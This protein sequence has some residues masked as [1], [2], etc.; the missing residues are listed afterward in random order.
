MIAPT[1]VPRKNCLEGCFLRARPVGTR[2]ETM[3][4]TVEGYARIF[5]RAR[6]PILYACLVL[7]LAGPALGDPWYE[8]YEKGEEAL[9]GQNWKEAVLQFSQA[10]EKRGDPGVQLRTSG[11]NFINYHPYLKLGIAYYNLGQYDAALQALSTEESFAA[12]AKSPSDLENL[13]AFRELAGKAKGTAEQQKIDSI[14]SRALED[15]RAF[16][17]KGQLDEAMRVLGN[18]LAVNPDGAEGQALMQHLREEVKTQEDQKES[19]GR[20]TI[21]VNEGKIFMGAGKYKEAS[22]S[23]TQALSLRQAQDGPS[24]PGAVAPTSA[25]VVGKLVSLQNRVEIRAGSDGTWRLASPNQPL[26]SGDMVRTGPD[27]RVS[28][29]YKNGTLHR[30]AENTEIVIRP[31]EGA[32][33]GRSSRGDVFSSQSGNTEIQALLD[34][35]Q[36][37]LRDELQSSLTAAQREARTRGGLADVSHVL[38]T[39]LSPGRKPGRDVSKEII[40]AALSKLQEILA[41]DQTNREA[42]DLQARLLILQTSAA[43]MSE[44]TRS[45]DEGRSFLKE[46]RFDKSIASFNKAIALDPTNAEAN[47]YVRQAY[48]AIAAA[49]G[50]ASRTKAETLLPPIVEITNKVD[51]EDAG[52]PFQRVDTSTFDLQ[53]IVEYDRP[54]VTIKITQSVSDGGADERVLYEEALPAGAKDGDLYRNRFAR[55]VTLRPGLT[56]VKVRAAYPTPDG[57]STER[58]HRFKYV[59]PW[60]RSPWFYS[61]MALLGICALGAF[62]SYRIHHR[63]KLLKRRFNPY[64]AGAPVLDEDMFVGREALLSRILQTIHNNSI[65]LY[66][67]RRIGKTTLQHHLKKRLQHVK[68]PEYDF[69]P[70]FIDLQGTPQERF[71]ATLAEDIFNELDPLVDGASLGRHLAEGESS[72]T[73]QA[74]IRDIRDVLKALK[75]RSRKKVKLVLL[76]DEVD[77]L[78]AY[79]PQINQRL[80]S[81]FMR[82]FA[83]DLVAVV[84]G[85]A[86]KKHWD[87]EG[88]PWYNF[89][90]EIEVKPFTRKDAEELIEK[91]IKGIF[92][93]ETGAVDRIID[94]TECK[95]YLIQKVC[96]ALIN[97]LHEE[98]R[99]RITVADVEALARPVVMEG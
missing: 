38:E 4:A 30:L 31:G 87:S 77:E 95:P 70:V 42:L 86:I 6:G 47:S 57:L 7:A 98:K 9:R 56:T 46:G 2:L 68:D 1:L 88:S 53:G 43:R 66:G 10:V 14:V 44:I 75:D 73:Y 64:V 74:F 45:L 78:N 12:I 33:V 11:V 40:T 59:R 61:A 29:L 50:H 65:L 25:D 22:S 34:E 96:I 97:R 91:P 16:E 84:S 54:G 89:F 79:E 17:Q 55:T 32:P 51:G 80:R 81:L 99:R 39:E 82:S 37:K 21:L 60:Y 72:Y 67:E 23:F 8:H 62:Q 92:Q 85:V 24:H 3:M 48:L 69:Y 27:S 18:A 13:R 52:A 76:I 26:H 71:F 19:S 93:L 94:K 41:L 15:A 35:S 83:E 20:I 63:N 49:L 28:I 36:S 5:R 58:T 90:E